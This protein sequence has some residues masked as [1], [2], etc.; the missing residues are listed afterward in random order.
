LERELG[1]V[2]V[3]FRGKRMVAGLRGKTGEERTTALV[4]GT[5]NAAE[6][7]LTSLAVTGF[8]KGVARGGGGGRKRKGGTG[9]PWNYERKR[10]EKSRAS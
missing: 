10:G 6:T 7:E 8:G 4:A 9:S 1:G 3:F 2:N 5:E